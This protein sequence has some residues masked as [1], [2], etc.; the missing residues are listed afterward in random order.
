MKTRTIGQKLKS[1]KLWCAVAGIIL[2]VVIAVSGSKAEADIQ[3]IAGCVTA[4]ISAITYIAAEGKID[5]S[6]AATIGVSIQALID[7]FTKIAEDMKAKDED[8]T[9]IEENE[10][11]EEENGGAE[12][13]FESD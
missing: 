2:G 13:D 4:L 12:N 11:H 3:T 1:T 6:S 8:G 9:S 10:N 7:Y 5:A